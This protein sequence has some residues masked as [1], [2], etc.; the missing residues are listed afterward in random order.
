MERATRAKSVGLE[1]ALVYGWIVL[2]TALVSYTGGR[3]TRDYGHLLLA[4]AFVGTTLFVARRQR[5]SATYYGV[6]LCGLLEPH[7]ETDGR[8]EPLLAVLRR[9]LPVMMR[10][11]GFALLCAL[12]VFPPFVVGFRLWHDVHAPF[13]LHLP[14]NFADFVLG[15]LVVVALPEETLFRGYFQTRLSALFRSRVRVLGAEL[16][17][18]A[19]VCQAVLFALL[20]FV[21]GFAP[22]R[23]A[24]FFPG[25]LFGWLRARRGGI[26]AAIWFH[27][28]SNLLSELLGRGYL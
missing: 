9:G 22:A 18:W 27:A 12:L 2:V 24:V 26:G 4:V 11:L 15:Q 25:L 13:T 1:I 14:H 23:L 10:E 20:H 6:D 19:L 5:V 3:L 8:A 7:F 16:S 28:F 17:P 21:V